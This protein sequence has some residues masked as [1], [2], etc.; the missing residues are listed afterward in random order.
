MFE[1]TVDVECFVTASIS[2]MEIESVPVVELNVSSVV[3]ALY[4]WFEL[5]R[6]ICFL[7]KSSPTCSNV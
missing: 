4:M 7:H 2:T 6:D 3:P 5:C 1:T